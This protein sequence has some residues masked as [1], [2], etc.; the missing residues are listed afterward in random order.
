MEE[1][2]RR[3][4]LKSAAL[5][6]TMPLM[7]TAD[8][9]KSLK[10]IHVTD[11]HMDLSDPDSID[12]VKLM[13]EYIN[14][15]YKDLDF[16]CFGGDNFNNN[17][18]G[19]KDALLFKK[20]TDQLNCKT[21]HVR[22]NKESSQIPDDTLSLAKFQKLFVDGKGCIKS[23][24]DFA[25]EK[26]GYIFLGLDSCIAGKNNGAYTKETIAFAKKMLT[27]GKPTIMMNH[28]PYTNF[29][30]E[31]NEKLIHNYIL[32][33][34]KEVQKELFGYDNLILTLSGHKHV[35]SVKELQGT[36]VIATRGFIR[37]LDMDMFPMRYVELQGNKI[38][39]KLIYTDS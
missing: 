24:K 10:F 12:A 30:G 13:V 31:T 16:V 34:T 7:A 33:N 9:A 8:E 26:N 27:K 32:N 28:H 22:G 20:I 35:D 14:T 6:A 23:G 5:V 39:E 15:N 36:K 3:D 18:V 2:S 4:F 37:P 1:L 19:D 25:Y 29:W 17:V 11:S 21:I 38:S